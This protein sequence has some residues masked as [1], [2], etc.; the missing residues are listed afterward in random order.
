MNPQ[1]IFR[2]DRFV[3]RLF[4][5]LLFM[6]PA[7]VAAAPVAGRAAAPPAESLVLGPSDQ[8]EVNVDNYPE[9]KTTTR[10]G[11]DGNVVL[12]LVGIVQ[13]GGLA[14]LDAANLIETFYVNGGFIKLPTVRVEIIDYQSRRVSVLG[15]VNRQGLVVLDRQYSLAEILAKVGGLAPDAGDTALIIRPRADGS[16]ERLTIEI[17]QP[18]EGNGM[19]TLTQ[20]RPGD[21]VMVP[22]APTFSV[23]GAVTRPGTYPLKSHMTV[24]QALAAAGD[25][26][27]FGSRSKLKVRRTGP[28]GGAVEPVKIQP[29]ELVKSGDIIVVSERIF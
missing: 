23:V 29:E 25:L 15:E 10:I 20:V 12:P 24:D 1:Q 26:S 11:A 14:P 19:T 8:I 13:L 4:L 6:S 21:V 17:G 16:S 18:A 9:L 7:M 3:F 5:I 27:P 28:A 22:K 2:G